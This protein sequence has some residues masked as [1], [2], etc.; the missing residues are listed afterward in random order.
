MGATTDSENAIHWDW[1]KQPGITNLLQI[2]SLLG[3][4]SKDEVIADWDGKSTYGPLKEAVAETVK[5]FL[6]DFQQKLSAVNT[7][8]L[9]DKLEADEAQMSTIANTTL[10]RVQQAVGLRP[11]PK[12]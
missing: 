11:K 5:E 3:N 2:L 7:D 12:L 1:E 10:E 6:N 4:K 9:M 8:K